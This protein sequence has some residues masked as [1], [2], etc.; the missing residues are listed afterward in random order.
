VKAITNAL[1]RP[2]PVIAGRLLFLSLLPMVTFFGHWSRIEVSIPGTDSVMV[3]WPG[4]PGTAPA[5]GG[6]VHIH[7]ANT[8]GVKHIHSDGHAQHC[9]GDAAGCSDVPYTGSS[10]VLMLQDSVR[11]LGLLP[12]TEREL[13]GAAWMP[14]ATNDAAPEAPPPRLFS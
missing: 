10:T 12:G 8:P 9:H 2:S 14:S 13:H 7:R 1:V 11:G 5:S 3:F 4:E 6:D